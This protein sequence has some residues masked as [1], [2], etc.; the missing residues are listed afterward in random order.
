M[1]VWAVVLTVEGIIHEI[2]IQEN[3]PETCKEECSRIICIAEGLEVGTVGQ[4]S[5]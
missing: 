2:N 4:L 3:H 1:R 5:K